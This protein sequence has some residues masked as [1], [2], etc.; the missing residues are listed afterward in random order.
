MKKQEIK[1]DLIRDKIISSIHY[2]SNNANYV[3]GAFGATLALIAFISF[4][5]SNNNK[6]MLE[7]NNLLGGLQNKIIH[8]TLDEND[9]LLIVEFEELLNSSLS[10]ESYNQVIVYLINKSLKSD[11]REKLLSLLQD[12][13]I[14]S[15]DDMLN[16]FIF[17][18]KADIASDENNLSDA[19]KYYKEAIDMVPSYDLMVG[20]SVNLID[21]YIDKADLNA[22]NLVF[23]RMVSITEDIDN[24]PRNTQNNIDFIE[25]KLKQ[26]NK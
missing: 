3:W 15:N 11:N 2:L 21:L 4:T 12:N 26:L 7:S 6:K 22:A 8:D 14:D 20:Y 9:S 19:I 18:L 24:L 17:K 23:D 13:S 25:Y 10:G 1:K 5:S 16:A